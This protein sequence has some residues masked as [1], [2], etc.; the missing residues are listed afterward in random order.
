MQATLVSL[1]SSIFKHARMRAGAAKTPRQRAD[2]PGLVPTSEPRRRTMRCRLTG[3][4]SAE[5]DAPPVWTMDSARGG[6]AGTR[7][8]ARQTRTRGARLASTTWRPQTNHKRNVHL[9]GALDN[10]IL[11]GMLEHELLMTYSYGRQP[12]DTHTQ[13]APSRRTDAAH[14][15][16][17]AAGRCRLWLFRIL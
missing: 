15:K 8:S 16:L 4:A 1:K 10:R 9:S 2:S 6:R 17:F 3:R 7:H 13:C 14:R 5:R 11:F 12:G